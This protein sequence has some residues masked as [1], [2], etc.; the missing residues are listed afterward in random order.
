[1]SRVEWRTFLS[2]F[3]KQEILRSYTCSS[4]YGKAKNVMIIVV[5]N[6]VRYFPIGFFSHWQLPVFQSNRRIS[7]AA[8]L[9]VYASCN[10]RPLAC[11]NQ[12]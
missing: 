7:Q 11:S 10:P 5:N 1:M 9:Q 8:T 6:Y 3:C 2:T 12:S 4:H